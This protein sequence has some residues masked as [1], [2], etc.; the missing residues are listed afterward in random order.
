MK[1]NNV[2]AKTGL[3]LAISAF[4]AGA[5]FAGVHGYGS[6]VVPTTDGSIVLAN[7]IFGAG[8]QD[9]LIAIPV[10]RYEVAGGAIAAGA[11]RCSYYRKQQCRHG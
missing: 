11:P 9:T 7:E 3:A 4:T 1:M 6:P 10:T 2:L 8:S 5:A